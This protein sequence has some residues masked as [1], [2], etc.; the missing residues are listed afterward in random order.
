MPDMSHGRAVQVSERVRRIVAPNPGPMTAQ[1][2]NTY[3]LGREEVAVVD[4]GPKE[5]SHIEAILKAAG[6]RIRWILVTHTHPDHSP[7]ALPLAEATGAKLMGNVIPDDGYQ[8]TTFKSAHEFRH[9]ERFCAPEFSALAL[10]TPGHVANHFCFLIEEDGLLLTGDHLMNG[11]TVVIIPP[12]GNMSDYIAS[13]QVIRAQPLCVLGPGHG[14]TMTEP[15]KVIDW[16]LA[17]R[18]QRERKVL[19]ALISTGGGPLETLLPV[20]YD[21]VDPGLHAM[22]K[23]SLWA[24]LLKLQKEGRALERDQKWQLPERSNGHRTA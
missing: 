8:D 18:L 24:H 5:P 3:L 16:V 9:E 10:H 4:P 17:H 2:T 15:I 12:H 6:E 19:D 13:L 23:M 20:V 11:S 22:A 1:G 7:A 14:D 21:D